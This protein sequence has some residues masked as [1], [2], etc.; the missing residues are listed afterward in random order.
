MELKSTFHQK[1]AVLDAKTSDQEYLAAWASMRNQE[2][3]R[4]RVELMNSS[5]KDQGVT[6][7]EPAA[8]NPLRLKVNATTHGG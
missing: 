3:Y 4:R 1:L 7:P 6:L 2:E 5:A 8:A